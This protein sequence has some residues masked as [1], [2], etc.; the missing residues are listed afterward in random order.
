[1]NQTI[2]TAHPL[3][4]ITPTA[5]TSQLFSSSQPGMSAL[6]CLVAPIVVAAVLLII[7]WH[8]V[9]QRQRQRLAELHVQSVS[10]K[11]PDDYYNREFIHA[12]FPNLFDVPDNFLE[13]NESNFAPIR[14]GW[15]LGMAVQ[16]GPTATMSCGYLD[17][18]A[19]P[20]ST[21]RVSTMEFWVDFELDGERWAIWYP[22]SKS[23]V[24][25][26]LSFGRHY[27]NSTHRR[28]DQGDIIAWFRKYG[29]SAYLPKSE[30]SGAGTS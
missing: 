17:P 23:V 30:S 4:Q 27:I 10:R 9:K 22:G 19:H 28:H 13:L 29:F 7:L 20:N 2:P 5:L 26:R 24:T 3:S 11:I 18:A 1:M 21:S 12:I 25:R 14:L 15:L 8:F 6:V 16:L